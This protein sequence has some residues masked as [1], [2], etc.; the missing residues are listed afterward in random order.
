MSAPIIFLWVVVFA[1]G[2]PSAWRNPTAGALVLCKI[3]GWV[4]YKLTGNNL[5][6]EYYPYVD[7]FV[8]AIIF[9]KPGDSRSPSDKAVLLIFALMWV[10]YVV[11]VD[12]Y[13]RWWS[14]WGL[15]ILKFLFASAESIEAFWQSRSIIRRHLGDITFFD[16]FRPVFSQLRATATGGGG[17]G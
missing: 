12:A 2:V 17:G 6:T 4:I 13:Y 3:A 5:P 10:A 1:V 9:C 14:L 11:P 15:V 8:I 16:A 7:A